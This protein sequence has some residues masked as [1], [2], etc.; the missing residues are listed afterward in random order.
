[1]LTYSPG[2]QG[3][4]GAGSALSANI[5]GAAAPAAAASGPVAAALPRAGAINRYRSLDIEA[6][7][8]AASPHGLVLMLFE[9]LGQL[10]GE[11]RGA[12]QRGDRVARCRAIERALALVDGLDT[13]LDDARGG[14]VA[15]TLHQAYGLLR[16]LIADGSD[17][18]LAEAAVMASTLTDAW[19]K[20][21]P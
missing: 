11:A 13:T 7:V 9:R 1:M 16:D 6:R 12:G 17:A 3:R 10:I 19:K 2:G 4:V 8:A 20:I 15:A 21:A 5:G 14:K 18:G